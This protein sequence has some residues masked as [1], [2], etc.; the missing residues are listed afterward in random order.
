MLIIFK[1]HDSTLICNDYVN[2]HLNQSFSFYSVCQNRKL[3]CKLTVLRLC[4]CD[5]N[6]CLQKIKTLRICKLMLKEDKI[7]IK[8]NATRKEVYSKRLL[9]EFPNKP[10]PLT[11]L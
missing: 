4:R 7:L 8:N 3:S 10:R 2:F 6:V 1:H 5:I 9:A 11:T